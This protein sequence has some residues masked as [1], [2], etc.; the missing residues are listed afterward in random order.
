MGYHLITRRNDGTIAN[1]FSETLEGLCQFDGIAADSIIYQAAEQWTPSIVGDDNTYK[2]L[3]EDWFRAGIRAQWQFYEEAKCQKL[4]PEK[5]N[6]DKE[7]FQAYT[8]A[9]TSSIKRGDYL[10]RAKNIEIEVKCLTLYGGHYYLPYSAMKSHQ[11]MQKLSSTPV[12]FAI[13]ERQAD[14]PVPDSLHMVSVADI[15][16]QNN[17]CVQYEKKSKCLRVPQSMTS[18]GFSGL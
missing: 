8:S 7:S 9:T 3:A 5:I 17:K 13:Y 10:L 6:Q 11:A 18:Q 15:F 4:I 2:L 16:E 1:H 14:T 12:W